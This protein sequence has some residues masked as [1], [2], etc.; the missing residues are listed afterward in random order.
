VTTLPDG[1]HH[2]PPS[3]IR[4]DARLEQATRE[5]VDELAR[6]FHQP[7]AAIICQIMQWGLTRG[8]AALVDHIA[9]Q[10][11][12]R[13]LHL[14]VPSELYEQVERAAAAAG[15]NIA[16]WLRHMVRQ[17]SIA[18]FPTSWRE[19]RPEVRAHDSPRYGTRFMLRLD[20]PSEA[21][22]QQPVEQFGVS[23]ADVVRQLLAQV[24]EQDFP[25]SWQRRAAQRR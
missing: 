2:T 16:A 19:A 22:L 7:R 24:H 4:I 5:K 15:M 12:V 18:D 21:K 10:A 9:S 8:Q 11:S 3:R 23:K 1:L 20:E 6:Y 17:I 25:K 13:H 14:Y